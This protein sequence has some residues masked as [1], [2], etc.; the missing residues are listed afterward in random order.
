MAALPGHLG[1]V[2][3]VKVNGEHNELVLTSL[4]SDLSAAGYFER[5]A[6]DEAV[7]KPSTQKL[8]QSFDLKVEYFETIVAAGQLT[9]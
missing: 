6:L 4:W 7:V 9:V 1:A 8:L 3:A 2:L 5:G